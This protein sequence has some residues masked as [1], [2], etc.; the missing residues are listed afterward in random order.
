MARQRDPEHRL[1]GA[2]YL[3]VPTRIWED[4]RVRALT[5]DAQSLYLQGLL[6]MVRQGH[7]DL[8]P[9]RFVD[10]HLPT[11]LRRAAGVALLTATD[12]WT[13][14]GLGYQ[15]ADW[16]G[17]QVHLGLTR[18]HISNSIR[19]S[20]YARD[21]HRCVTCGATD[22][23]SLDHIVPWSAGGSDKPDNLRTLCIPC[24][25]RKGVRR[26]PTQEGNT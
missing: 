22:R 24:N 20:V 7:T 16:L 21:H 2:G 10:T 15:V 23:L 26:L 12:L 1:D 6:E 5:V 9:Q 11:R 3:L 17:I 13:D 19:A 8:I 4:E 14:T 25:S 18:A